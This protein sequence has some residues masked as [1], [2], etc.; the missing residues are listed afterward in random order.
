M[1]Q[2]LFHPA[3]RSDTTLIGRERES[4]TLRKLLSS[5]AG[6]QGTVALISGEPG[7][8]K[9]RLI[10]DL[11]DS[12]S[13]VGARILRGGATEA[14]GMPPYLPFLEALGSAIRTASPDEIQSW[15]G[16]SGT[17]LTTILPELAIV[18]TEVSNTYPLPAEQARLRLF[19]GI[20]DFI[21]R[22]AGN[23]PAL[24]LLDDLQ[25]ADRDSLDLLAYIAR[26]L[27]G[28]RVLIAGAYRSGDT[29][30]NPALGRVLTELNRL[31]L[32]TFISLQ[33]LST[34]DTSALAAEVLG[35]N[36][37]PNLASTLFA[38]SEGNPFFAEELLRG[39]AE[40]DLLEHDDQHWRLGSTPDTAPPRSIVEA[41][42]VRLAG[43]P[44][45][46]LDLLRTAAIIGRTF[47]VDLLAEVTGLD[48]EAVELGILPTM[49]AGILNQDQSGTYRFSHDKIREC[50]LG[51]YTRT[52][53]VR[54]HGLIGRALEQGAD[55]GRTDTLAAI[56]FHFASSGDRSRGINYA[57]RAAEAAAS[58]FA[59]T[60]AVDQYRTALDLLDP[61]DP[62]RGDIWI[63]LG[64]ASLTS[65]SPR[66]AEQA[67]QKAQAW[68]LLRDEWREA[69]RAAH[70]RGT[71]LWR[72]E[73]VEAAE[74]AFA[75][76]RRLL[77]NRP[78][79]ETVA[80][81]LDLGTLQALNLGRRESGITMVRQ[82]CEIA[83][84]LN[85]QRLDAG[86]SRGLGNLLIREF[87][88]AQGLV[89]LEH[90]LEHYREDDPAEAAEC[91]ACLVTAHSFSGDFPRLRE[92]ALQQIAFAER[93]QD[94]FQLRNVYCWLAYWHVSR[95]E[96]DA[97]CAMLDKQAAIVER[98]ESPE[99]VAFLEEA[100]GVIHLML[101]DH[102]TAEPQLRRALEL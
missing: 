61:D 19:E 13:H 16:S 99:P 17:L 42:R 43:Y 58:T 59:P 88:F 27:A 40:G 85:D 65:N 39:W 8:G 29:G 74:Q 4:T 60:E 102:E 91:C 100:R 2:S 12:A 20:S 28:S 98:L 86:A 80:L 90:A 7:I 36:T 3:T 53:R 49:R 6:G 22:M 69:A 63:Q 15:A 79:P 84:K 41:V 24:L 67:Y 64:A 92:A 37:D 81:L 70:G 93:C 77:A 48:V 94:S 47:D 1:G 50:L 51:D 30:Q 45:A 38:Q 10:E 101:G 23:R 9:S 97:A 87:E 78:I 96:L 35:G 83:Q 76:A 5:A 31:R 25:W 14:T 68:H 82:A 62:R 44:P 32:A 57:L 54:I 26:H 73:S 75:D 18:L 72:M 34:L 21:H 95:G 66:E 55:T 89:L 33:P 11:A 56:A 52:R 46:T 71:A